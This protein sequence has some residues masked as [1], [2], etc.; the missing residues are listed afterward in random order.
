MKYNLLSSMRRAWELY[1]E[2]HNSFATCL[3]LAWAEAKGQKAYTFDLASGAS[4]IR[5]YLAGLCEAIR[6][7]LD[8]A[9]QLHKRDILRAALLAPRDLFGVAVLDGKSVGLCKY[10]VRNA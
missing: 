10:A 5:A 7:G 2:A 1:R 4:A 3:R 8:D 6:N 9:H